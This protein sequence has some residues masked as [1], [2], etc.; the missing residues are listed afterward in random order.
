MAREEVKVGPTFYFATYVP[1]RRYYVRID[2]VEIVSY[3]QFLL[4]AGQ[5]AL[6]GSLWA[7]PEIGSEMLGF[8]QDKWACHKW[9]VKCPFMYKAPAGH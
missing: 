8:T 4:R 3:R 9:S 1:T 2:R 5:N 6:R 7:Y